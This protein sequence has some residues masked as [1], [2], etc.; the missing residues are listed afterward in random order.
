MNIIF[1]SNVTGNRE[2]FEFFG[3]EEIRLKRGSFSVFCFGVGM[4]AFFRSGSSRVFW[5]FGG[6]RLTRN[7]RSWGGRGNMRG[8]WKWG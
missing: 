1:F 6:R 4:E 8:S 7:S 3:R 2:Q 5:W